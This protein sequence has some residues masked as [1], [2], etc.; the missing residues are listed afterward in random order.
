MSKSSA[1]R[2]WLALRSKLIRGDWQGIGAKVRT[3]AS[4]QAEVGASEL[5]L[6]LALDYGPVL[7][8]RAIAVEAEE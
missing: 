4:V 5:H 1:L 2:R 6:R 3:G 8:G 7:S